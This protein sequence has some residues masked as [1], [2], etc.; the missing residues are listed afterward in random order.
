MILPFF[1]TN[2]AMERS[3]AAL[4][5]EEDFLASDFVEAPPSE[6]KWHTPAGLCSSVTCGVSMVTPVMFR[7]FEKISGRISTPTLKD[8]AVRKGE[9]LNLGSSPMERLSAESEP[10]MR[11]RLRFPSCTWRPSAAEAFSSMVGRKWLT[12]MRYGIVRNRKI[13]IPPTIGTMRTLHVWTPS[14]M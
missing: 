10:V 9:E 12:G 2:F 7:L 1:S 8:L 11:E 3:A 13:K 6:E 5:P 4:G 14:R